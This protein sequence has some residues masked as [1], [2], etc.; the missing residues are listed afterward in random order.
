MYAV[1]PIL[2]K[3]HNPSEVIKNMFLWPSTVNCQH[4]GRLKLI[5][6]LVSG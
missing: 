3:A 6:S 5:K 2:I 1:K 4:I